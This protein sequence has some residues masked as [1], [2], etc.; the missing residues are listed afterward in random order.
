[1]RASRRW[2]ATPSR[3][4]RVAGW[5]GA[6]AWGTTRRRTRGAGTRARRPAR[7]RWR[8]TGGGSFAHLRDVAEQGPVDVFQPAR[9][10][11]QR[12]LVAAVGLDQDRAVLEHP[13]AALIVER[14]AALGVEDQRLAVADVEADHPGAR[15]D[16]AHRHHRPGPTGCRL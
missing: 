16:L 8:G 9:V 1:G 3:A 11:H 4:R 12:A 14:E 7:R 10:Q 15:I 2:P 5:P 6:P 13:A